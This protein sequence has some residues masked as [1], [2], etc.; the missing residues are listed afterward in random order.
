MYGIAGVN[1]RK[2]QAVLR[3]A[4]IDR[5]TKHHA[6]LGIAGVDRPSLHEGVMGIAGRWGTTIRPMVKEMVEKPVTIS[7]NRLGDKVAT[8]AWKHAVYLSDW[9]Y[10]FCTDKDGGLRWREGFQEMFSAEERRIPLGFDSASF[11][12]FTGTAPKW[13]TL[14]NYQ[15]AIELG[16]PDFWMHYDVIGDQEGSLRNYE[17]MVEAGYGGD[18]LFP[19]WQ[20]GP[21]WDKRATVRVDAAGMTT[22]AARVA[23]ANARMA[24]SDPVMQHYAAKHRMIAIGGMVKG[25]CP[26]EV[27][28]VY[29]AEL[30]R[31]MP[32]HQFWALGQASHVVINGLGMSGLL[33]RVSV[34]GSWWIHNARCESIAVVQDGLIKALRLEGTGARSF[35]TMGEMML[36]NLRSGLGAYNGDWTFPG[37]PSVPTDMR[38]QDAVMEMKRRIAPEQSTLWS[39]MGADKEVALE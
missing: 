22:E 39:I 10:L 30:C 1:T 3:V 28:H 27:R 19:V 17:A 37:P 4:G 5:L 32:D 11:R 18:Q 26:R 23:I 6:V 34:D 16:K 14:E 35:F 20:I 36:C 21:T 24:V 31:L 25:P 33:N 15:M 38:D 29:L 9:T 13:T 2:N 12:A 8:K 7:A